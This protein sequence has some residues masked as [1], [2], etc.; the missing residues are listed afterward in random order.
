MSL[1]VPK[2]LVL[3]L[4]IAA[5]GLPGDETDPRAVPTTY[6]GDFVATAAFGVAMNDGGDV[7]GTSYRDT[8]CGSG[9]LPPLDTV[10]WRRGQRVVLP[11]VPGLS[12]I[13]V[14]SINAKGWV[15]GFAGFP[16]HPTHAVV[17]KPIGDSVRQAIDLGA[18]PGT[19]ISTATGIDD[20]GRVVGWSTTANFPPNGSPFLWTE[21]GGMVDLSAQGYPD[22]CP[23]PSA[24]AVPW[25]TVHLVSPGRS[26]QHRPDAASTPGFRDRGRVDRDQRCR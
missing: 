5:P 26:D 13:T 1:R 7:A 9:C 12:G 22:E 15:A 3:A 17:W 4:L 16:E 14:R 11:P 23:S 25:H 10:V 8:G 19:T 6:V 18:L 20:Q 24:R 2:V 21:S